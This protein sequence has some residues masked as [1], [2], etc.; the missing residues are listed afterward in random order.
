MIIANIEPPAPPPSKTGV[1]N[2][3][4]GGGAGADWF[5]FA[6]THFNSLSLCKAKSQIQMPY[7]CLKMYNT[8]D[9]LFSYF[10]S[11]VFVYKNVCYNLIYIFVAGKFG[12]QFE[13][14]E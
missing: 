1:C 10:K 7:P 12:L 13:E 4:E 3:L 2:P 5:R 8:L 14:H 9:A 11:W 6:D